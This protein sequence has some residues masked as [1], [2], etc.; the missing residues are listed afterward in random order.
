MPHHILVSSDGSIIG[1]QANSPEG[2][3]APFSTDGAATVECSDADI[4]LAL[5]AVGGTAAYWDGAKVVAAPPS[6]GS[7]YTWDWTSKSWTLDMAAGIAAKNAQITAAAQAALAAVVAAYPDLEVSTW[8]QQYAEA[9]AYTASNGA[10]TPMLSA[11]AAASGK[12]VAA[13]AA[14]VMAKAAAYQAAAGAVVGKRIALQTKASAA[15]TQ[16]D[17]DAIAW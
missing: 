1:A 17:L 9:Q 16:A 10:A 2:L 8:P 14:N 15:T 6:P 7:A 5:P 4:A 11:I 3:N 12:T 13:L